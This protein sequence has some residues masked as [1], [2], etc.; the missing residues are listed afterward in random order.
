MAAILILT[1]RG[2]YPEVKDIA[3]KPEPEARGAGVPAA[4]RETASGRAARGVENMQRRVGSSKAV[5]AYLR[6]P[7]TK[8]LAAA[9]RACLSAGKELP[10]DLFIDLLTAFCYHEQKDLSAEERTLSRY[11]PE[12]KNIYRYVFYE[13]RSELADA[14]YVLPA[15]L[16]KRLRESHNALKTLP[17]GSKCPSFGG[18]ITSEKYRNGSRTAD[19]LI[20]P[21]CDDMLRSYDNTFSGDLL[22]HVKKNNSVLQAL[23]QI[24]HDLSDKSGADGAKA[25]SKLFSAFGV[26]EGQVIADIGSG[27]GYLTF[28]LAAKV[29]PKGRVYAE[30]IDE[31]AVKVIRYCVE[32]GGIKNIEPVLGGSTDIKIPPGILDMAVMSH[33]YRDILMYLDDSPG[34]RDAF[35]DSFFAGVHKALKKDGVLVFSESLDPALGLSPE[36]MAGALGKRHFRLISDRSDPR[37][38]NLI[39][40][41]GKSAAPG[42]G[43]RGNAAEP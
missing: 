30:D 6:R 27:I 3:P 38:Q 15:V 33:V 28:P 7:G 26:R 9:L 35:L 21:K 24:A 8:E 1:A 18:P 41:F 23:R 17:P 4:G 11:S 25:V 36:K 19:R 16:C 5:L 32:K 10:G 34:T 42:P 39:L 14:L 37:R 31:D 12:F 13:N 2:A 43:L 29:G 40:V 22:F 20:C